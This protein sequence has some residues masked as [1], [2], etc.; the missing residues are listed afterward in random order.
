MWFHV[1]HAKGWPSQTRQDWKAT[2]LSKGVADDCSGSG[3]Q[4][5][6]FQDVVIA[7]REGNSVPETG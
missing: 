4:G 2:R 1:P 7:V 5:G 3:G 6:G